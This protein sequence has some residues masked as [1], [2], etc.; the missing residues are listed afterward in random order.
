MTSTDGHR[1]ACYDIPAPAMIGPAALLTPYV[2]GRTQAG[3]V[4]IPR[5]AVSVLKSLAIYGANGIDCDILAIACVFNCGPF[6]LKT[7]VIDGSFPDYQR[8]IPRDN[9]RVAT[10]KASDLW[11]ALKGYNVKGNIKMA[12][13]YR[14]VVL[15]QGSIVT[16]DMIESRFE[17]HYEGEPIEA[18]FN[19]AYLRDA[20]VLY[21]EG[22]LTM[23]MDGNTTV[24]E[25]PVLIRPA[26]PEP[27]ATR[28]NV[29]M[30]L[31]V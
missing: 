13:D 7:K 6:T 2:E 29:L 21:G 9:K 15:T 1:L 26:D 31:R 17:L 19:L 5:K 10:F 14:G 30:P 12:F 8:V 27:I 20:L 28:L 3:G 23:A 11:S 22:M 18:G 16:G 4:I 25:S 24:V